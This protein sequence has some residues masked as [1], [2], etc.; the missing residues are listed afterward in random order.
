MSHQASG[1]RQ[2]LAARVADR[3]LLDRDQLLALVEDLQSLVV[4]MQQTVDRQG[5]A[6]SD[7]QARTAGAQTPP[8]ELYGDTPGSAAN[9][10]ATGRRR[11]AQTVAGSD[12]TIVFDGGSLGNPGKGYG[13][14]QIVDSGGVVAEQSLKFGD[15]ITNNQAEFMT[16]IKAMEDLRA[17]QGGNAARTRVAIRGDSQLVI[18]TIMGKWKARHPGL[19]PL[20]QQ[21]VSLLRE[22]GRTDIK[23]QP[24]AKSVAVLGH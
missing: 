15:N 24:R 23:W 21:A 5:K 19:I 2:S 7:L 8:P 18:N 16:L 11:T 6:I 17:R 20:H 4:S 13:S 3:H 9:E 22:F 14:Y 12:F 10:S 1:S